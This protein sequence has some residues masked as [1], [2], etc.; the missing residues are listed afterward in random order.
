M[1]VTVSV[2]VPVPP[3]ETLMLLC[4][5]EICGVV[6]VAGEDEI[7][8]VTETAEDPAA[9]VAVHSIMD[10]PVAGIVLGAP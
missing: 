3:G 8:A 1:P 10:C 9:L 2:T 4:E 5:A 6:C 7:F